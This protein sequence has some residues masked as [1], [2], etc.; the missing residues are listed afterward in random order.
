MGAIPEIID[1]IVRVSY[2][3]CTRFCTTGLIDTSEEVEYPICSKKI[4]QKLS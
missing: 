1:S 4:S 3:I 2:D